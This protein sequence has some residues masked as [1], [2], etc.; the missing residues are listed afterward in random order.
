MD[1]LCNSFLD[2]SFDLYPL[3]TK[4]AIEQNITAEL[5][6]VEDTGKK[7]LLQ[8]VETRLHQ[9]TPNHQHDMQKQF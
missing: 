2:E 9:T 3:E 5:M 4:V 6:Q 8:F 1:D 7:Q